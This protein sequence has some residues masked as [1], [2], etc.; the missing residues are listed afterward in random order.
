MAL[1][2]H[3]EKLLTVASLSEGAYGNWLN[4]RLITGVVIAGALTIVTS[5]MI[6]VLALVGFYAGYIALVTSGVEP[7]SSMLIILCAFIGTI[8]VL[9]GL[10]FTA[11]NRLQHLPQS[12]IKRAA[13]KSKAAN[14]ID[15]F[16]DGF[17]KA[18]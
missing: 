1:L 11:V 10:I 18:G 2:S 16:V 15:A 9:V 14:V 4:Q 13:I 17:K 3:M 8:A 5:I 12:L 6:S 7:R